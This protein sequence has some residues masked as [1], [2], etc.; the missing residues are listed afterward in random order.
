MGQLRRHPPPPGGKSRH[1]QERSAYFGARAVA[2]AGVLSSQTI[3]IVKALS[4]LRNQ[5]AHSRF[6][7][8]KEAGDQYADSCWKIEKRIGEEE[9]AWQAEAKKLVDES[10][11][12]L[13][14]RD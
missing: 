10:L 3:A 2:E 14:T 9:A 11:T 1:C 5:V 7:P 12:E 4:S 13:G 8:T 6:E